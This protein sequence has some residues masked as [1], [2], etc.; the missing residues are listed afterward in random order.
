MLLLGFVGRA[1]AEHELCLLRMLLSGRISLLVGSVMDRV[2]KDCNMSHPP[3]TL[4]LTNLKVRECK[5]NDL[6]SLNWG[7]CW[8]QST[9]R[10]V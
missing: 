9:N 10:I 1:S 5:Q 3:S 6:V 4:E 8:D 7:G 2:L